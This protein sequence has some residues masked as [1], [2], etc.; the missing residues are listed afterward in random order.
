MANESDGK[1]IY[2]VRADLSKIDDDL[3]AADRKV[4]QASEKTAKKQEESQKG[5]VK[6]VKKAN[7]DIAKDTEKTQQGLAETVKKESG[8]AA[9]HFGKNAEKMSQ[10][11]RKAAEEVENSVSGMASSIISKI[12]K[13]AA[14]A[15][16]VKTLINTMK[17][18]IGEAVSAE[19]S[20][21]KVNTLLSENA[22][23]TK[24]FSDIKNASRSTGVVVSDLSEAVYSALSASVDEKSAVDFTQSAVKLAKGGFTETATAVDVLTTAINAYNLKADDAVR[25]SDVLITTQ[26]LG[27][28]TVGELASSMGQTI[29]IANSAGTAIEDLAAQ[30]AVMTKNGVA[31]AESGTQIKAMLNE[32]SAAGT[33]VSDTLKKLTGK[34]FEE[35]QKSGMNTAEILNILKTNA[36]ASGQKLS[37]MFGSVEAGAAALTLVKDG[38]TDFNN[39]L[40]QM[41]NSAG[42]T[43]KAYTT[44]ANTTE[45]RFNK[46]KNNLMIA[47]GEIGEKLLPTI[48]E[49]FEYI[50]E[51]SEELGE[52]IEDVGGAIS[53]LLKIAVEAIKVAWEHKDVIL[54]I[55]SAMAAYKAALAISKLIDTFRTA[56]NMAKTA[57]LG[58][59]A[60]I[61]SNPIG[62]LITGLTMAAS[63]A[64][65][66]AEAAGRA[67]EVS[68]EYAQAIG[69]INDT[70]EKTVKNI[71]DEMAA[72]SNKVKRYDE[73]RTAANL[74]AGEEAELKTLASELQTIFGDSVTV[75]DGL[76][77]KYNDLTAALKAYSEQHIASS[78]LDAHKT[79]LSEAIQLQSELEQKLK[80]ERNWAWQQSDSWT[81]NT[82]GLIE[83]LKPDYYS[84]VREYEKQIAEVKNT[85]ITL[86]DQIKSDTDELYNIIGKSETDFV[87]EV[88]E[89]AQKTITDIQSA[90]DSMKSKNEL[91]AAAT[92]E[93]NNAGALSVSTLK[94]ISAQ[95]PQLQEQLDKYLAGIINEKELMDSL[96][97]AY[98]TDQQNY[99]KYLLV[100]QGYEEDFVNA[101][102]KG[103]D[104]IVDY[105]AEN[106][107]INLK[108]FKDY[109]SQKQAIQEAYD[110]YVAG[111]ISKYWTEQGGWT[112]EFLKLPDMAKSEISSI[113]SQYQNA[114]KDLSIFPQFQADFEKIKERTNALTTDIINSF[115][116]VQSAIDFTKSK[117][118]LLTSATEEVNNA[119]A[120]SVSTL[121]SISAQYPQLQEQ[122]D[123]Y[124]I[125]LI[126]EQ[127][128]M[129][130]LSEA[131]DT[132][133]QNY[134]KYLLVKQGY[135]EDFVNA[136]FDGD[137][138]IVDYFADNYEIDL[139]NY[140]DYISRKQAIQEA[141]DS[142]VAGGVSKYWTESGGWTDEFMKLPDMAK[143]G[144]SSIV[145]QYQNAMKDLGNFQ[146]GSQFQADFEKIKERTYNAFTADTKAV[147]NT[148]S[149][150]GSK[151]TPSSYTSK[152]ASSSV[153]SGGQ[154]INITSYI[155]TMWDDAEKANKKLI[156]G[157]VAASLVGNSKSGKLISGL[158][159]N[160][161]AAVQSTEK[162]DATL[163]DVVKAIK[164][165]EQSNS[166]MQ[167][168]V[169]AILNCDNVALARQTIKGVA[170]IEKTT[171]KKVF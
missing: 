8:K 54:A 65:L 93:V 13:A 109:I 148:S 100:K 42:A 52:I 124:L 91:L 140:K 50:D 114:M 107:E 56:L 128:L 12:G 123:K 103:D 157:G 29:P 81:S 120:F 15:A 145:Y 7:S 110:S 10:S 45:E 31:T 68:D 58:L 59:N 22:D 69:K 111:G 53:E 129:K 153:G 164:G 17:M 74:T 136:A 27:K 94:S 75:V 20:F 138:A 66:Y 122:V 98:D 47:M 38:G 21:A 112:D 96:S 3:S 79:Q 113:V 160:T 84:G 67:A 1:V 115:A 168:V 46:L 151:E 161:A 41:Q 149:S 130:S 126:D 77:G 92:E 106:Y 118:E 125:G 82:L 90:L 36:E 163:N 61:S 150:A 57:Q 87:T 83:W 19:T 159:S 30:Y 73:L 127:E 2:E 158:T 63:V 33:N 88:E 171:G 60:A 24:Y 132:D 95:Y 4:I 85:I 137:D 143:N 154:T 104:A 139:K 142:Y 39:I 165:L 134:Y 43:E 119:G 78:V 170:A 37:D 117:Y 51:N 166:E 6:T 55:I 5:V 147:S 80:E 72:L 105:F 40:L 70:A 99:Y 89:N 32:L 14:A 101:A 34:S 152:N 11:G 16:S 49:F 169:T 146:S 116:D 71:E 18:A 141:Y 26:N 48:E 102:L 25:V 155:P 167:C 135:E 121:K 44:M 76:T 23:R 86:K 144:I 64:S 62:L 131:Y 35:L 9:E 162:T 108:N 97:E 28:T 156:A 133:Q